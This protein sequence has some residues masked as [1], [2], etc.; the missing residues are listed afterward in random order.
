MFTVA[1]VLLERVCGEPCA[2]VLEEP[3]PSVVCDRA[4][5]LLAGSVKNVSGWE[6]NTLVFLLNG[7]IE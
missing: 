1:V 3:L 4:E 5:T 2:A 6:S 7:C